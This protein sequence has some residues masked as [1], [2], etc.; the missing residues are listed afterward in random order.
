MEDSHWGGGR[1]EVGMHYR[2]DQSYIYAICSPHPLLGFRCPIQQVGER[3][4]GG[5]P[6]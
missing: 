4:A 2:G 5:A 1:A 3:P 6:R